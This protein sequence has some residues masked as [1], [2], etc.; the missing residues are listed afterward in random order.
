MCYGLTRKNTCLKKK[1]LVIISKTVV[2]TGDKENLSFYNILS[3][4]N[5]RSNDRSRGG[6]CLH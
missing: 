2:L 1:L 3:K 4:T 6:S 5:G